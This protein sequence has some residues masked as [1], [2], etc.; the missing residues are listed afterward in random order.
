MKVRT[1]GGS[2]EGGRGFWERVHRR[3]RVALTRRR[4]PQKGR[5]P[6]HV[7]ASG[8]GREAVMKALLVAGADVD[9]SDKVRRSEP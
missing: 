5:T 2:Q 7:A 1:L 3:G 6:L 8:L 4:A 9:A